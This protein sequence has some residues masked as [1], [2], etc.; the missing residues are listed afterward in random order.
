KHG[1]SFV[2][3]VF[4]PDLGPLVK[5]SEMPDSARCG[6]DLH[7]QVERK[8]EEMERQRLFYVAC[9]RA[10]D[11][12]LLSGATSDLQKPTGWMNTLGKAFGLS[13]G[14]LLAPGDEAPQVRV[15]LDSDVPPPP[16]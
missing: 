7:I 2:S 6:L 5:P 8:E 15:L 10:E 3:A 12:L 16:R 1:P 4:D 14:E 13:T 9:T 11:Y